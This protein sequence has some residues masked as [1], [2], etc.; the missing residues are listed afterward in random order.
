MPLIVNGKGIQADTRI[1]TAVYLQDIMPTTLEMAG[2]SIPDHVQ[3]KSLLSLLS[4]QHQEQ[5]DAIYGA[6]RPDMQ[7]MITD[8][9]FKLILYPKVPKLLLFDLQQD[10]HEQHDLSDAGEH[11]PRILILTIHI[12][13]M[14]Q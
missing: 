14:V 4:G 13:P 3:F 12:G 2:A 5:Y 1:D 10:P 9:G 11:Q 7:R 6:Y 8:D